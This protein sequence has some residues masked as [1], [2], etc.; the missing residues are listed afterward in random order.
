MSS[1]V[2][3]RVANAD[4][5]RAYLIQYRT[6]G[7]WVDLTPDRLPADKTWYEWKTASRGATYQFRVLS[8][9]ADGQYSLPS[10]TLTFHTGG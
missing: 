4:T 7:Q 5:V 2:Q 9:G 8:L 6:V 3:Q 1:A 10:P